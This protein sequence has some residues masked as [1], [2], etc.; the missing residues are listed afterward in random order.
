MWVDSYRVRGVYLGYS[1]GSSVHV[2][3]LSE[4]VSFLLSSV[5]LL[6]SKSWLCYGVT[7]DRRRALS[8]R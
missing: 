2:E 6:Q 8:E 4:F 5:N 3:Y 7:P 1:F